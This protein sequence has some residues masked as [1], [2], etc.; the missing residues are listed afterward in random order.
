[1]A[2]FCTECGKEIAAGVAFCTECGTKVPDDPQ[3]GMTEATTSAAETKADTSVHTTPAPTHPS[4]QTHNQAT[5]TVYAPLAPDP[6][7]KVVGT[8]TYFGLMILFAIPIVGLIA[9]IIM[10]FAPKNKNLKNYAR[11][12]LIWS[13]IALV[14]TGLMIAMIS[15]LTNSLMDYINRI[16]NE[17]FKGFNDFFSQFSEFGDA[18]NEFGNMTEQFENGGLSSLPL[19]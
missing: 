19:E 15:L 1:M 8:G 4:Q 13:I 11:A 14:I 12:M 18:M 2:K 6:T 7:N 9:C 3:V 16:S 5:Q 10:S 17:Q